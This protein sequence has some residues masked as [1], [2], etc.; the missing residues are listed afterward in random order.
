[1]RL[2]SPIE[3]L[4]RPLT[5]LHKAQPVPPYSKLPPLYDYVMR[6]VNYEHWAN[7]LCRLIEHGEIEAV[8]VL[9]IA[10]GTGS[11]ALRLHEHGLDV[12]G[13]D[14]SFEMVRLARQ[15][16]DAAGR[17]TRFWCGDMEN[18]SLRSPVDVVVCCYDSLNYCLDLAAVSRVFRSVEAALRP[19]GL[20]IFD[21]CTE[22]NSR[23]NFQHYRENDDYE[24]WSYMRRSYYVRHQ[25]LQINEFLLH[26]HRRGEWYFETHRQRIFRLDE[27]K[28][29]IPP[30]FK[31]CGVYDGFTFR[32]GSEKSDRVHFLLKKD[33][34]L[35]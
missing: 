3:R 13:F 23:H 16:A 19:G 30:A 14:A 15:K 28:Q 27:L 17:P 29:A 22:R 11:M 8:R 24:S 32:P 5:F 21:V 1:M 35:D 31:L 18:F 20:F 10:C 9:D 6:H 2:C 4:R 34:S 26:D 12:L 25:R 7:H 33:G